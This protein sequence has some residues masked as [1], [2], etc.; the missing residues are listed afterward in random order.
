MAFSHYTFKSPLMPLIDQL[1]RCKTCGTRIPVTQLHC[2]LHRTAAQ[3]RPRIWTE[4]I[5]EGDDEEP[6][7]PRQFSFLKDLFVEAEII[8]RG[9]FATVYRARR[10]K[11]EQD[12]ALKIA[13]SRFAREKDAMAREVEVLQAL[14]GR[15]AP[16]WIESSL[17]DPQRPDYIILEF[18]SGT[19]LSHRLATFG[20]ILIADALEQVICG[21]FDALERVHDC[22]FVHNDLK[23]E[24]IML[25]NQAKVSLCDFDLA[26]R[27][28]E[29]VVD[30]VLDRCLGTA[31]YMAPERV[32]GRT[33]ADRRSD[34]YSL[35]VILYELYA[36]Y[37][38]FWGSEVQVREWQR[39]SRVP[40]LRYQM[41][42]A[43]E[44]PP[45]EQEL[46]KITAIHTLV[47][48][49]LRKDP[50]RR[51]SSVAELRSLW[52]Q[53]QRAEASLTKSALELD[54]DLESLT[55]GIEPSASLIQNSVGV[56]WIYSMCD[57][58]ELLLR[59]RD[60]G[61]VLV[62]CE[63]E[64]YV[65]VCGYA[66]LVNPV[67]ASLDA[68]SRLMGTPDV[69]MQ[70]VVDV[71]TAYL[72]YNEQRV[73]T[74]LSSLWQQKDR[75]ADSEDGRGLYIRNPAHELFPGLPVT[76]LAH[77]RYARWE[78][79]AL[80]LSTG[81]MDQS[82]VGHEDLIRT[83][84]QQVQQGQ[85][86]R[87]SL[88]WVFG[89]DGRGKSFVSESLHRKF[90]DAFPYDVH[91]YWRIGKLRGLGPQEIFGELWR[92][93]FGQKLKLDKV[94]SAKSR[95]LTET[96]AQ[97]IREFMSL[98]GSE[99]S[100]KALHEQLG[101]VAFHLLAG[102]AK[103]RSLVFIVDDAQLLDE[104]ILG[105]LRRLCEAKERSAA[106]M[107]FSQEPPDRSH[108]VRDEGEHAHTLAA[109]DDKQSATLARQLL[110]H[111]ATVPQELLTWV[112]TRS[113]GSPMMI[114]GLVKV[115]RRQGVIYPDPKTHRWEV[116]CSK[117][118]AMPQSPAGDWLIEREIASWPPELCALAKWA[119]L[120]PKGF[121]R[122]H[123]EDVLDEIE[124]KQGS[125]GSTMDPDY[126]LSRL[127]EAKVLYVDD[128]RGYHFCHAPMRATLLMQLG[129][130][131]LVERV[132]GA[133]K[134]A[135]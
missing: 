34:I 1:R 41:L 123:L 37:P 17:G 97:E 23:P 57:R 33:H 105:A 67:K 2:P 13:H 68:A 101:K 43:R 71:S 48:R 39:S 58:A 112:A 98:E 119:A 121:R 122:H 100:G 32:I 83:L 115:L 27:Q 124:S 14:G 5:P 73:P 61:G 116:D 6:S 52:N 18:L 35:G 132:V 63:R 117:L 53:A 134:K 4:Q 79:G 77:N 72:T 31:E 47:H 94:G 12:V 21:I 129:G 29:P 38:P 3:S 44:T 30:P 120:L 91:V 24:N 125:L 9:G 64:R 40:S 110:R 55:E 81:P 60:V 90:R 42:L 46:A 74:F 70:I 62:H 107:L 15:G 103:E 8:G 82:L 54:L 113:A 59:I 131:A 114:A 50:H 25:V 87:S 89:S 26:Q 93:L 99:L 104:A 109:L 19:S 20:R 7:W 51:P 111:V 78:R 75:Y 108:C 66:G 92:A 10:E 76:G 128:A 45:D 135:A 127:C 84:H 95:Y 49:C 22:G 86:G 126:G 106:V 118:A 36:G 85:R 65:V 102:L 28:G 56:L 80:G 133:R 96:K 88:S 16:R 69:R 11:D 130:K